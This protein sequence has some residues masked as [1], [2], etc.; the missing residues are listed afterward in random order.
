MGFFF[1]NDP[2]QSQY[3]NS[4]QQS[5]LETTSHGDSS[6]QLKQTSLLR[7]V[8]LKLRQKFDGFIV[9]Y[10]IH[11]NSKLQIKSLGKSYNF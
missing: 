5:E 7:Y 8:N 4:V 9:R 3:R 10:I 1:F 6:E 11:S 2:E